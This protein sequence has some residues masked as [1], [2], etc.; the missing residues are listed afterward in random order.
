VWMRAVVADIASIGWTH[1]RLLLYED[2][3]VE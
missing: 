1:N 3:A 2:Q